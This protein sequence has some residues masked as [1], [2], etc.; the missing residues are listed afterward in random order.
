[1]GMAIELKMIAGISIIYIF[2]MLLFS[3]SIF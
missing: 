3:A 2:P 1:M